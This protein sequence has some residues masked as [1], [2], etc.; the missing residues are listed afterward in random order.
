MEKYTLRTAR[1]IRGLSQKE[2]AKRIGVSVE[3]LRNYERG[4]SYPD[5]PIIK[6]IESVYEITY[7]RLIFL[8]SNN[9]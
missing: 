3:T 1:D 9:A 2:A 4:K 6:R 7:D 8:K 5:V